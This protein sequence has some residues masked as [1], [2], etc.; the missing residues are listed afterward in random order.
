MSAKVTFISSDFQNAGLN[1]ALR[2]RALSNGSLRLAKNVIPSQSLLS[3]NLAT[4]PGSIAKNYDVGQLGI[5]S[6]THSDITTAA[7]TTDIIVVSSELYK[8]TAQTFAISY[9]GASTNV[10]CKLCLLDDDTTWTFSVYEDGALVAEIDCGSNAAGDSLTIS[11]LETEIEAITGGDYSVTVSGGSSESCLVLAP[12]ESTFFVSGAVTLSFYSLEIIPKPDGSTAPFTNTSSNR[13]TTDF[14]SIDSTNARNILILSSAYDYPVQYDGRRVFRVGMPKGVVTSATGTGSGS[15][16][17]DYNYK[18]IYSTTDAKLNNISGEESDLKYVSTTSKASI[19]VVVPNI[20][21]TTGFATDQATVNG[22]QT[23]VTTIT[24]SSGHGIKAGD[25]VYLMD[26]SSGSREA[27]ER[28]VS[29]VGSTTVAIS[30]AAVNV[31]NGD[32]IS[33]A[34]VTLVRTKGGQLFYYLASWPN[35]NSVAST[36][37][38]DS[39]ADGSLGA[40]WIDHATAHTLPPKAAY[41]SNL[42]GIVF[43]TGM[44]DEP[45]TV[46]FS[47]VEGPWYLPQETSNTFDVYSPVGGRIKGIFAFDQ[48]VLIGFTG[49]MF[50]LVGNVAE[51]SYIIQ[52]MSYNYGLTSHF[53]FVEIPGDRDLPS[54]VAYL[55]PLGLCAV[56]PGSPPVVISEEITPAIIDSDISKSHARTVV[57]KERKLLLL[58]L[59]SRS[60]KSGDNYDNSDSVIYVYDILRKKWF[61][62]WTNLNMS[63]GVI[64]SDSTLTWLSRSVLADSNVG[65][66]LYQMIIDSEYNQADDE[67]AIDFE[68]IPWWIG[69][70]VQDSRLV[71][72]FTHME[73]IAESQEGPIDCDM[74]VEFEKNWLVGVREGQFVKSL[75]DASSSLGFGVAPFGVESFGDSVERRALAKVKNGKCFCL[76][77]IFKNNTRYQKAVLSSF[78]FRVALHGERVR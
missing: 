58:Y 1:L 64:N 34:L 67:S 23:G 4:R 20:Q 39:V 25:V 3:S 5:A 30:G 44:L 52:P 47:D 53:T 77:P 70:D 71:K 46:R 36:T 8:R 13:N 57:W 59:P 76:R 78:S 55:S 61:G 66:C 19:D 7:E 33:T 56:T 49:A 24:V 29:S 69:G 54:F 74:Q 27:I 35:S 37:Y 11:E 40:V 22:A 10:F 31:N 15:F 16:G 2:D 18:V 17:G 51:R 32:I 21:K 73:I 28:T 43:Y 6:Y 48:Y 50:V 12:L 60:V 72:T 38:S 9:A 42:G 26:R 75:T 68:I 45:N 62:P 41:L 14:Q 63:G 65:S